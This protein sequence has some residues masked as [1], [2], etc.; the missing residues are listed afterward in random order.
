M[1]VKAEKEVKGPTIAA[2]TKEESDPNFDRNL[3]VITAGAQSFV[4]KTFA[5]QNNTRERCHN[6]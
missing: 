2:A 3:D 1:T 4:K 6:S 5:Y